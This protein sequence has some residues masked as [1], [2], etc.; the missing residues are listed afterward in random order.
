MVTA[1]AIARKHPLQFGQRIPFVFGDLV[2]ARPSSGLS[3]DIKLF[4]LFF[5]GGLTFLSVYLA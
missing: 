4:G 2:A 5:L 3:E 1:K